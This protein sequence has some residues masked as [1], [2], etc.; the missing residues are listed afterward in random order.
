MI[1]CPLFHPINYNAR[2]PFLNS[3][4]LM[5][6]SHFH[7]TYS[8]PNNISKQ[9]SKTAY[10]P[11]HNSMYTRTSNPNSRSP[12]SSKPPLRDSTMLFHQLPHPHPDP[13]MTIFYSS[14]VKMTTP[15]HSQT[16]LT[17]H[18]TLLD[19]RDIMNLFLPDSS[20]LTRLKMAPWN[21]Q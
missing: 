1:R 9:P 8:N 14:H 21:V 11:N 17:H 5:L 10:F 12:S 4:S 20:Y 7:S 18:V 3:R 19:P 6:R 13:A 16:V 2:S 15:F